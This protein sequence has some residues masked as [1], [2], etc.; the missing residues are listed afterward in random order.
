VLDRFGAA[1]MVQALAVVADAMA[2]G[3]L[4]AGKAQTAGVTD[5]DGR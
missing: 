3:V 5:G 2:R 1:D 4:S